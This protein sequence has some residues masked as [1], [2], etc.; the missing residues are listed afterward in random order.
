MWYGTSL[1]SLVTI[2]ATCLSSICMQVH[3]GLDGQLCF[4]LICAWG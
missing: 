1:L 2:F 4:K 3:G